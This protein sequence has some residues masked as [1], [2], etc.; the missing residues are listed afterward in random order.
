M[1]VTVVTVVYNGMF[2]LAEVYSD[3]KRA[4]KRAEELRQEYNLIGHSSDYNVTLQSGIAV[5]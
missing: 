1:K 3:R 2:H 4:A 5:K